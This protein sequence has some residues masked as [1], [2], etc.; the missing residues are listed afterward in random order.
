MATKTTGV[1][2][3]SKAV[4]YDLGTFVTSV[5]RLKKQGK[6]FTTILDSIVSIFRYIFVVIERQSTR[7]DDIDN[8][9]ASQCILP[10]SVVL[11][12]KSRYGNRI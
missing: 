10:K 5:N 11:L 8:G 6:P 4:K 3:Y 12:T 7:Y 1:G 9:I 2:G